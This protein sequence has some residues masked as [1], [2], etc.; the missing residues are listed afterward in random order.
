MFPG[1]SLVLS[2]HCAIICLNKSLI[3]DE[4]VISRDERVIKATVKTASG[5]S[6]CSLFT[7]Y[8][9]AQRS[10]RLPF[11]DAFMSLPFLD[12]LV[13]TGTPGFILGDLNIQIAKLLLKKRSQDPRFTR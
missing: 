1:C 7:V 9:P 12:D 13:S 10:Q 11:L 2:K 3:L 5:V 6:L 4:A 8:G